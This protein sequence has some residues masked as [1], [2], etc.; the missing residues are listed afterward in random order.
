MPDR[1]WRELLPKLARVSWVGAREVMAVH[2][3]GTVQSVKLK[4][5]GEVALLADENASGAMGEEWERILSDIK[6]M[7]EE[8]SATHSL[9]ESG[10][11]LG[12]TDPLDG[13]G[14]FQ[15]CTLL[16]RHAPVLGWG[17]TVCVMECGVVMVA[18]IHQIA[19]RQLFV[20]IK[21]EGCWW[22][23]GADYDRFWDQ[24][25]LPELREEMRFRIA[26]LSPPDATTQP[27]ITS[28]PSSSKMGEASFDRWMSTR[29]KAWEHKLIGNELAGGC[30]V[31]NAINALFGFIAA[32]INVGGGVAWDLAAAGLVLEEAGG[33]A[34]D[35]EGNPLVWKK[36]KL[37]TLFARDE[38][39]ARRFLDV[40]D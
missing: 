27:V 39:T 29:W 37:Q 40:L 25:E 35:L 14:I 12:I 8:D 13:S 18:V 9:I 21:G 19:T 38:P 5:G 3:D 11:L 6:R 30:A 1:N 22:I 4:D 33:W 23:S 7:D 36:L 16:P 34:S 26:D 10:E 28:A 24:G 20:A 2:R 17:S 15:R 32:Y 31:A